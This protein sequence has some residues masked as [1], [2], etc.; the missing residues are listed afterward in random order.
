MACTSVSL[1]GLVND[2]ST[3][4]GGVKAVWIAP[5]GSL[6]P[7]VSGDTITSGATSAFKFYYIRKGAGSMTSTLNVDAANGIN[8]VSTEVVLTFNKMETTKRVE[9]SALALNDVEVIVEDANSKFW[10]LGFDE[11]V[12]ATAGSGQ[13]G[14]QKTDGN[15]YSITLTDESSTWPYEVA[16]SVAENLTTTNS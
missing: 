15:F 10:F 14:Q 1:K 8:Y 11:P 4:M 6:E 7:T 3:S 5:A 13:T 2:C 16:A 12:M 9:M